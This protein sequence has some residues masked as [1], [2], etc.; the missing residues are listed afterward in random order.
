VGTLV[1]V[2]PSVKGSSVDVRAPLGTQ[3]GFGRI[4]V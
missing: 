3:I 1:G 4:K 2:D